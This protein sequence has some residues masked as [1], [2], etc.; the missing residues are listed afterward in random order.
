MEIKDTTRVTIIALAITSVILFYIAIVLFVLKQ[1]EKDRKVA[2]Q[3]KLEQVTVEKEGVENKLREM[4]MSGAEMRSNIR[5]QEDRISSLT[6][7]VEELKSDSARNISKLQ[8]KDVEVTIL[9]SKLDAE[10]A[11]K[12]EL[13]K[14]LE[15]LNEDYLT[16]KIQLEN[17]MKTKE[18]LEKQAKD[19]ADQGGISLGSIVIKKSYE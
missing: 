17:F 10:K 5:S 4:E 6:Q 3:K 13:V 16:L 12:D 18:E 11:E 19:L 14:R 9:R 1:G 2:F 15:K 7:R 8:E